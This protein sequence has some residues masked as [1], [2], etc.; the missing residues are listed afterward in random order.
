MTV[1]LKKAK[2]KNPLKPQEA[3]KWHVGVK[4]VGTMTEKKVS[5]QMGDEVTLNPK[6]AE[7]AMFQ[8]RKVVLNGLL[9]GYTVKLGDWATFYITVSSEGSSDEKDANASK[10]KRVKMHLRY[11]PSFDEELQKASFVM[12][13]SLETKEAAQN[14]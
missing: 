14:P 6:E 7:M 10:V 5:A 12:L 8:L 13:E 3:E 4:S 9:N 11:D 2:R 1:L